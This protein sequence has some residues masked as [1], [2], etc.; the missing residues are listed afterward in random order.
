M[1]ADPPSR[2]EPHDF[3]RD[4]RS[5]LLVIK[6]C[7]AALRGL[8]GAAGDLSRLIL[9]SEDRA[10]DLLVSFVDGPP[11]LDLHDVDVPDLVGQ[12]LEF[13]GRLRQ[14]P[15]LYGRVEVA[16]VRADARKLRYV[17]GRLIG[18]AAERCAPGGKVTVHVRSVGAE[19]V[20]RVSAVPS[21]GPCGGAFGFTEALVRAHGGR[22]A[23]EG[24]DLVLGLPCAGCR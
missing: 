15:A 5:P 19:V 3:A 13:Q 17:L 23:V 2:L 11:D 10:E 8:G 12:E 22:L 9:D 21:V 16:R 20:F 18:M 4:L 14:E 6:A 1:P 7:A 24:S